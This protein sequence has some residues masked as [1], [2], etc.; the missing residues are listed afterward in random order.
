MLEELKFSIGQL[1]K[2]FGGFYESTRIVK[3][4]LFVQNE[5]LNQIPRSKTYMRF[6]LYKMRYVNLVLFVYLSIINSFH[7]FL[8]CIIAIPISIYY[9]LTSFWIDSTA[10][11]YMFTYIVGVLPSTI[12]LDRFGLRVYV[13]F[14]TM[15]TFIGSLIKCFSLNRSGFI[16]LLFGQFVLSIGQLFIMNVPPLLSAIWFPFQ[17]TL[18]TTAIGVFGNQIGLALGFFISPYLMPTLNSTTQLEMIKREE[19]S[20][21]YLNEI[22]NGLKVILITTT[23]LSAI[24]LLLIYFFFS[25]KP[26]TTPSRA[27]LVR[28]NNDCSQSY[29]DSIKF[30]FRNTNFHF[31]FFNYGLII[32]VFYVICAVL[33]QIVS[34]KFN[35][36]LMIEAGYMATIITVSGLVGSI[37]CITVLYFVENFKIISFIINI[38]A[39][40]SCVVFSMAISFQSVKIMYLACFLIGF[41]IA[42]YIPIGFEFAAEIT[43]PQSEGISSAILN[44]SGHLFGIIF[45]YIA[46]SK[47]EIWIHYL[48]NIFVVIAILLIIFVDNDL[49]RQS[50]NIYHQ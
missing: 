38:L 42:G 28:S 31:L 9:E 7:W 43:Y 50:F 11:I 47:I 19:M 14:G 29:L 35:K 49:R 17:E 44:F 39:L 5:S 46:C 32:G 40:C 20:V 12:I 22:Y 23:I 4:N 27:Q 3:M 33:G 2:S 15:A 37:F 8:Y 1:L 24:N 36:N 16:F 41:F 10:T 30:I 45:T 25:D 18:F 21:K 48:N 26:D 13:L 34:L 6:T